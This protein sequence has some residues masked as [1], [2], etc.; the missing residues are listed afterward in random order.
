VGEQHPASL[1]RAP[2]RATREQEI[3]RF[4]ADLKTAGRVAGGAQA[5]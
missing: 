3:E 2:D 4:V 1:L 5:P